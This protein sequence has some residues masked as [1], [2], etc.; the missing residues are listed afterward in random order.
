MISKLVLLIAN[1][2]GLRAIATSYN[3]IPSFDLKDLTLR[4]IGAR[5]T[6]VRS[7]FYFLSPLLAP[8]VQKKIRSFKYDVR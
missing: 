3:S 7:L 5:D 6:L 2:T 8:L 1:F 4:E